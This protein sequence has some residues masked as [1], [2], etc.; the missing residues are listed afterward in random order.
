MTSPLLVKPTVP[1][2]SPFA[3]ASLTKADNKEERR[4]EK[5]GKKSSIR[6]N[7]CS[8]LPTFEF[9]SL[10][11]NFILSLLIVHLFELT[12]LAFPLVLFACQS[13]PAHSSLYK[14]TVN[15]NFA[16]RNFQAHASVQQIR[17]TLLLSHYSLILLTVKQKCRKTYFSGRTKL[18]GSFHS[19]ENA[20]AFPYART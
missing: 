17:N 9:M 20:L 13:S 11:H 15:V 12:H 1:F 5:P 2:D 18:I 6:R 10:E 16:T 8:K 3:I 19:I 4:E 7:F 14:C